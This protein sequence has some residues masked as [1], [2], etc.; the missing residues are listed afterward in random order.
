MSSSVVYS[1]I[2]AVA[3]GPCH[4][5]T[6]IEFTSDFSM[7]SSILCQQNNAGSNGNLLR[8]MMTID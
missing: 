6:D 3:T 7:I 5:A 1:L 4:I 8:G 2:S